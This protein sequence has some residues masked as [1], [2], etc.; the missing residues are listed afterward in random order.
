M[1]PG[2]RRYQMHISQLERFSGSNVAR[3]RSEGFQMESP[4]ASQDSIR[5]PPSPKT[6]ICASDSGAS[7]DPPSNISL[8]AEW[9]PAFA[10]MTEEERATSARATTISLP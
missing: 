5:N 2:F 1:D 6:E 10:G 4:T 7:R 9:I 3:R 8:V